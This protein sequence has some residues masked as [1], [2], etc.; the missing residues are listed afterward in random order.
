MQNGLFYIL[1][2][3]QITKELLRSKNYEKFQ[4]V[5][6]RVIQWSRIEAHVT[7]GKIVSQCVKQG[8]GTKM[9]K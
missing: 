6:K 3:E 2:K 8:K 9:A 1:F 4:D 5:Y 7:F